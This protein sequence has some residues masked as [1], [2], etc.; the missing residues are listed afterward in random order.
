MHNSSFL[1]IC[2]GIC[3]TPK[4]CKDSLRKR[5]RDSVCVYLR[6]HTKMENHPRSSLK[7]P[8]NSTY[9]CNYLAFHQ[10]SY[11]VVFF[12]PFRFPLFL[13]FLLSFAVTTRARQDT[14]KLFPNISIQW[15]ICLQLHPTPLF[16]VPSR[17][18]DCII[19]F[20][21]FLH[22]QCL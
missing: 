3:G 5:A 19:S 8:L 9:T 17:L 10:H 21:A 1:G 20:L 22:L 2:L 13:H 14:K 12:P 11:F 16:P 6:K 4:S 15:R 7:T 18:I